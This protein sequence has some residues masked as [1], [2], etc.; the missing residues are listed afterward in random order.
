MREVCK[1]FDRC[2]L[3][4]VEGTSWHSQVCFTLPQWANPV[5]FQRRRVV[6]AVAI[7]ARKVGQDLVKKDFGRDEML[8]L[9]NHWYITSSLSLRP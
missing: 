5:P 2:H 9:V 6:E 1:C 7:E 8:M 3:D 4:S